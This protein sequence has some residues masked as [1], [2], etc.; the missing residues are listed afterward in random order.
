MK[1]YKYHV[2]RHFRKAKGTRIHSKHMTKEA[3]LR[4]KKIAESQG[5]KAYIVKQ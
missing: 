5:S 2:R 1:K 4:S 3:A